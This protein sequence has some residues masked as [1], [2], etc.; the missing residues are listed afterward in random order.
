MGEIVEVA[1]FFLVRI[2]QRDRQTLQ[3]TP[4]KDYCISVITIERSQRQHHV[5][6]NES[7]ER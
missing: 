5:V 3:Q 7:L 2:F 1:D 4:V 6:V